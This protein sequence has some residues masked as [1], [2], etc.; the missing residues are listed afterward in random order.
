MNEFQK[1]FNDKEANKRLTNGRSYGNLGVELAATKAGAEGA[2]EAAYAERIRQAKATKDTKA[3]RDKDLKE[4]EAENRAAAARYEKEKESFARG[5]HEELTRGAKRRKALKIEEKEEKEVDKGR[6]LKQTPFKVSGMTT[7]HATPMM[8]ESYAKNI[9]IARVKPRLSDIMQAVNSTKKMQWTERS[10]IESTILPLVE[11]KIREL[12]T[13]HIHFPEFKQT[14]IDK[15]VKISQM[16]IDDIK[17]G[18][19]HNQISMPIAIN[20]LKMTGYDKETIQKLERHF[21]VRKTK[22]RRK[23]STAQTSLVAQLPRA[24]SP[25]R[26]TAPPK[27]E[28]MEMALVPLRHR[29]P[30]PQRERQRSSSRARSSRHRSPSK[31]AKRKPIEKVGKSP[32]AHRSKSAGKSPRSKSAGRGGKPAGKVLI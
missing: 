2:Q 6:E 23:S 25:L 17:K 18:F 3:K 9:N 21:P 30:S 11:A 14:K 29:A 31:G 4:H 32:R 26:I 19:T 13:I 7:A 1:T 22:T 20:L 5:K 24:K 28:K 16:D 27:A 8:I 15:K 12:H 10:E